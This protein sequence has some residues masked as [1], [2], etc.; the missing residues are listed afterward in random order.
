MSSLK[1]KDDLPLSVSVENLASIKKLIDQLVSSATDRL[2]KEGFD[3]Y[4]D[5][6]IGPV[7]FDL[8]TNPKGICS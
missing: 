2:L 8:N 1:I 6:L 3:R 5:H 7:Y 4:V